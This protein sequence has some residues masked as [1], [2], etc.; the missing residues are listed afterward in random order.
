MAL[1]IVLGF[2]VLITVLIVAYFTSV[3]TESSTAKT[4]ANGA[5]TKFLADSAVNIVMGQIAK[6]TQGQ[7]AAGERLTW[8]SQPGMIRTYG[9][10]SAGSSGNYAEDCYKLYS[11]PQM[12]VPASTAQSGP[13]MLQ[14]MTNDI[15]AAWNNEPAIFTDLNA[16]VTDAAGKV[17]FPIIDGNNVKRLF[18]SEANANVLSYRSVPGNTPDIEGFYVQP[19]YAPNYNSSKS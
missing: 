5:A 10:S 6:G 13:A 3:T 18:V 9:T 17:N 14:A 19:S 16:P 11:S 7:S 2:L 1:V 4:Y 12:V 15:P 8:A